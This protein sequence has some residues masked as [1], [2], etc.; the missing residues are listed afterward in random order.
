MKAGLPRDPGR[1]WMCVLFKSLVPSWLAV[2]AKHL[3]QVLDR[4][5]G[6][7]ES[8]VGNGQ[9]RVLAKSPW[10]LVELRLRYLRAPGSLC[11]GGCVSHGSLLARGQKAQMAESTGNQAELFECPLQIVGRKLVYPRALAAS[12][13]EAALPKNPFQ[14]LE[15]GLI[16]QESL[17]ASGQEAATVS[18]PWQLVYRRL[19]QE[20]L[21]A[22]GCKEVLVNSPWQLQVGQT[23]PD[24]YCVKAGLAKIPW[25]LL[26]RR[27]GWQRVS[28]SCCTGVALARRPWQLMDKVLLQP[29]VPG[30]YG[31]GA[32]LE[33]SH[34]QLVDRNFSQSSFPGSYWRVE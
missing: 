22:G 1:W 23:V 12:G 21:V 3:Y 9:E 27:L 26:D 34:W 2:L 33:K 6:N 14:L 17:G 15:R 10:Q 29:R 31:T 20:F 24:T 18:S 7:Q 11:V 8:Q 5:L 16:N 32:A 25:Q 28:G 19:G 4:R 13:Q 30:S